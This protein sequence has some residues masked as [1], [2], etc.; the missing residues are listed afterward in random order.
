M[1]NNVTVE[2]AL[3][4]YVANNV[5]KV[6]INGSDIITGSQGFNLSTWTHCEIV[7]SSGTITVYINGSSVG[8]ASAS[9]DFANAKP[10]VIG[11]N[12]GN[13]NGCLLY[14][15]PSPRDDR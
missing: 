9:A 5:P 12:Y 1:R 3:Y 11:N 7:R 6:Y 10:L 13:T 14:T 15:S 2:N 4:F 8:S